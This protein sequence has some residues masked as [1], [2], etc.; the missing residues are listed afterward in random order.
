[1]ANIP[2][3]ELTSHGGSHGPG[4]TGGTALV[5]GFPGPSG[6]DG[7]QRLYLD[8]NLKSYVEFTDED[9][10]TTQPLTNGVFDCSG[11][12]LPE[13]KD[14]LYWMPIATTARNLNATQLARANG[15]AFR[16]MAAR[17][18]NNGAGLGAARFDPFTVGAGIWGGLGVLGLQDDIIDG[19]GSIVD[20]VGGWLGSLF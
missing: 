4:A 15:A 8:P 16:A 6:A 1:M 10:V 13:D 9:P 5:A 3:S 12:W 7:V 2:V 19:V 18:A 11:I 14:L 20:D 17:S